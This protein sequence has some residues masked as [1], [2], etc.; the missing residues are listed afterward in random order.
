MKYY[1]YKN[2]NSSFEYNVEAELKYI[3]KLITKKNE[4]LFS[5]VISSI[6]SD[7]IIR[8]GGW[9]PFKYGSIS[10]IVLLFVFY[11]A[12]MIVIR[13]LKKGYKWIICVKNKDIIVEDD[14]KRK[15]DCF[16]DKICTEIICTVSLVN[17]VEE[18][19]NKNIKE[20]LW[21]IYK[22]QAKYCLKKS[23]R[24]LQEEIGTFSKKQRKEY[25][26]LIGKESID[27]MID[28][29]QEYANKLKG[30]GVTG[31]ENIEYYYK[32]LRNKLVICE[33]E[34]NSM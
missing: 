22:Y 25:V 24:Y 6:I 33:G 18:L 15:L 8:H 7:Y 5:G 34:A 28:T 3:S 17:R 16:Y 11:V 1:K 30:M 21:N 12:I 31:M 10:F 4:T 2:G 29:C 14:V 27:W 20:E 9:G 13:L 32:N 19:Q 23:S 26:L